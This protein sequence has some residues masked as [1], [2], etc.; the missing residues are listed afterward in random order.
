[1]GTPQG[2]SISVL[3]SHVYWHYVLDLWF[4]KAIQPRLPGEAYLVRYIDDFVVCF[5]RHANAVRFQSP[6]PPA[7]NIPTGT[8]TH[9]HSIDGVWTVCGPSCSEDR[10]QETRDVLFLGIHSLLRPEPSRGVQSGADYGKNATATE[11]PN[12]VRGHAAHAS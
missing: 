4:E 3:L 12:P 2:G 1:M 6:E 10:P 7:Q 8:R 11:P 9:K 5:E